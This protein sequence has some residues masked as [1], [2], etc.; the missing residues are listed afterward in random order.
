L[1]PRRVGSSAAQIFSL[2]HIFQPRHWQPYAKD[3]ANRCLI[4]EG[5][6]ARI[7]PDLHAEVRARERHVHAV[8]KSIDPKPFL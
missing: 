3:I 6:I 5:A 8:R 4:D 2:Q 7:A 1:L